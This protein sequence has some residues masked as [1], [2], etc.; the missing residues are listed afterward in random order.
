[1]LERVYCNAQCTWD[2]DL[3]RDGNVAFEYLKYN[4]VEHLKSF[5]F[6]IQ[7]HITLISFCF[8]VS[9]LLPII[10]YNTAI[11]HNE[12]L[13]LIANRHDSFTK[14]DLAMC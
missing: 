6:V 1:M 8:N 13:N 4:L 2:F 3:S 9:A 10:I 7:I 5:C 11:F 14:V 12:S